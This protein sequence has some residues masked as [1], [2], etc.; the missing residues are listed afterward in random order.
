[1]VA[2]ARDGV[3]LV[4]VTAPPAEGRAND[5]V[6]AVLARALDLAPSEVRIER[7]GSSRTKLVSLPA[8]AEARLRRLVK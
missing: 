2:G 8:A 4:R 6:V 5:A 7:G 3:L 1:A